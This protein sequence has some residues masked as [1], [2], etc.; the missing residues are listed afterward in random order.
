MVA[1]EVFLEVEFGSGLPTRDLGSNGFI[2]HGEELYANTHGSTKGIGGLSQ[3]GT[4]RQQ[5]TAKQVG[6]EIKIAKR[7]P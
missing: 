2:A 1:D 7:E 5:L 4:L 3:R 6:C